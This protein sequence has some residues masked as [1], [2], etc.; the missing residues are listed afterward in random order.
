[1]SRT[2][3]IRWIAEGLSL[4]A[5]TEGILTSG[6]SM[7]NFTALAAARRAVCPEVREDG[8][9]HDTRLVVYASDQVHNCVDKAIDLLGFGMRQLRRLP[10]DDAFPPACRPAAA[11]GRG[12]SPG[13]PPSRHRR[14]Q[15]GDGEH[16]RR[17]SARRA[18]RLLPQRKV[19]GSMSTAPTGPWPRSRRVFGR[20]SAAW[21]GRTRS[22]PTRTSGS[23]S[24]SKRAPPSCA[25]R[26]GSPTPFASRPSTWCRTARARSR[27]R[28]PSTSA[29]RS[30]RAASRP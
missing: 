12:R 19:S 15:R 21:S 3:V 16:G 24:P 1:M 17:R 20:S 18:G 8:L 28:W 22:P 30:C 6:G 14:G 4:P 25:S 23:T 26:A 29:G 10:A 2:S 11:G 9:P 7:A 5:T 13:R 27:G